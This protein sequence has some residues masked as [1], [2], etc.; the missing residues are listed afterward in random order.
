[1]MLLDTE[2][3]VKLAIIINFFYY[4][5]NYSVIQLCIDVLQNARAASHSLDYTTIIRTLLQLLQSAK[6]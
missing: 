1:M 6:H 4:S 2:T 3:S 5:Y